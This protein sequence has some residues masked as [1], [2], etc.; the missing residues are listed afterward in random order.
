MVLG[1]PVLYSFR[2]CPFA[3]RARMALWVS[4]QHCEIREVILRNK[5]QALL[6]LSSKATV[7]VLQLATG[8]VI[9]QSLEI[10]VWTLKQND[11]QN[12]LSPDRG[13]L[14]DMF[15][16]IKTSDEDFKYNLDHYKYGQ[17]YQNEDPVFHRNEGEKF[18]IILEEMLGKYDY[19]FGTKP[20]LAD[21]AILPF[22]RQFANIERKWFDSLSCSSIY[23][24]LDS[25]VIG[26][27]V[28][29]S[30]D[31]YSAWQLGDEP[32]IFGKIDQKDSKF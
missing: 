27:Y 28:T 2:R 31:K 32:S 21:Y 17:R 20:S 26:Q 18:L 8:Q 13:T 5:P 10:M 29:A 7:P 1:C 6:E 30:M 9:E 4:G 24:W 12:W 23:R 11:P 16:L 19:L 3:M 25:L 14:G 15:K 22:I